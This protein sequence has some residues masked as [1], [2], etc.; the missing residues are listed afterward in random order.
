MARF[1]GWVFS[2]CFGDGLVW[3]YSTVKLKYE[4]VFPGFTP[5]TASP[6]ACRTTTSYPFYN[7]NSI[8]PPKNTAY[9]LKYHAHHRCNS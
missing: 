3:F 6:T 4:C 9:K 5:R 7:E 8:Q 2:G 1:S